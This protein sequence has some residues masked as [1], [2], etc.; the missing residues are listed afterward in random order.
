MFLKRE[1]RVSN[2]LYLSFFLHVSFLFN[3]N[4]C[5]YYFKSVDEQDEAEGEETTGRR[6][7]LR[8]EGPRNARARLRAAAGI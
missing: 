7:V 3:F 1:K 6:R 2:V 8:G 4:N 5:F